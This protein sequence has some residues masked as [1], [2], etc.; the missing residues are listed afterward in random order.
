MNKH[1]VRGAAALAI[2][3]GFAAASADAQVI[4]NEVFENPPGGIADD[5]WEYIEFYGRPGTDLTGYAVGLAKGGKD[6]NDDDIPDGDD[7]IVPE[8]D[9]VFTLDGCEIGPNG[10]FVLFNTSFGTS[11]VDDFLIP[12][13]DFDPMA[14]ETNFN[15]PYLN[16]V[17]FQTAHIPSSDTSGKLSNDNSSTYLLV[18]R[19]PNHMIDENGMS[20]YL[21]GYAFRK[22]PNPDV[23]FDGKLDF[24]VETPAPG[25][26]GVA[27]EVEPLQIVDEVAWSN[28]GGKE[29]VRSSEQEISETPGFN[30]DAISRINY[31]LENPMIGHRTRDLPGGGFEILPTRTAD[32]SWVYGEVESL[33][34]ADALEYFT[35]TDSDGFI[36]FRG[37]TDPNATPYDGTCDP[38]PDDAP[39]NPACS[40]NPDGSYFFTELDLAGFKLSPAGFNDFDGS[41][42]GVDSVTQFRFTRG[43]FN[44]DGVVD[45][46]D[47]DLIEGRAGATLDDTEPDVFDNNTPDDPS[48]DVMFDRFIWQGRAF[49]Q[50]LMM[51]EMDMTDGADGGNAEFITDDDIQ[52]VRDLV[53]IQI[54]LGDCNGDGQVNFGDL[55]SMLFAFG[56]PGAAPEACDANDD[57][58]INFGDLTAA[59]FLFGPCP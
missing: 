4:I 2:A 33:S 23:D 32:E 38:E 10:F 54:C 12:N 45:Q 36:Q 34:G 31:F 8:F 20:I 39:S 9:E 30:P 13:P 29:Y 44:F 21:T 55:T 27:F 53:P 41:A 19:R 46:D 43:D 11:F 26:G 56:D 42:R 25:V 15:R 52:A 6:S 16:G 14:E 3:A 24:G 28:N 37:P 51:L 35:G 1:I 40:P 22:E 18:R 57:G 48:D 58:S 47:L 59:L 17:A 7:E 5:V 50:T 49:Q